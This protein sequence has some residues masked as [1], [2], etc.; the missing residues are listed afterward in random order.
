MWPNDSNGFWRFHRD[1]YGPEVVYDDFIQDFTGADFNA[2][3]WVNLFADAGAKYFVIGEY[4][5]TFPPSQC[6][7]GL[8][9]VPAHL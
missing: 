9:E 2:S 6:S 7:L 1:H 5:R 3:E 4:A 8:M